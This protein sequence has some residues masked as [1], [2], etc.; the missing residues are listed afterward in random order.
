MGQ[1]CTLALSLK[2]FF[3]VLS[4]AIRIIKPHS[5]LPYVVSLLWLWADHKV[6]VGELRSQQAEEA[7]CSQSM[8]RKGKHWVWW[9][10]DRREELRHGVRVFAHLPDFTVG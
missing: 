2:L 7:G 4:C 3:P 9:L 6:V 1:V 8:G 5:I 10:P